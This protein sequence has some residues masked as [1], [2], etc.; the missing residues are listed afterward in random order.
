M[1]RE[2]EGAVAAHYARSDLES[3][4]LEQLAAAGVDLDAL[5]ARDLAPVD[6]FHIGGL[7]ASEALARHL[8][9]GPDCALLDIGCGIGGP[10][11]YFAERLDA[12]VVGIDLTPDFIAVA[13]S[14]TRRVGLAEQVRF[15]Q[16]S[17]L[18]LPFKDA[19]FDC[20]TLLHVGMNIA[21]KKG[22]FAE[23]ARVLR[24]GAVF[25]VYDVMRLAPGDLTFPLPWSSLPET[26][27]VASPEDYRRALAAAG[28]TLAFEQERAAEAKAFFQKQRARIEAGEGGP[29]LAAIM[30]ETFQTK[31]ANMVGLIGT[32]VLAPV[33]VIAVRSSG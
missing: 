20:A 10:A 9:E 27:F 19:Q 24:P 23:A 16:A 7:E 17:A 31:I 33:E 32:G 13:E 30:G 6:E 2:V 25:A 8:P 5:T 1:T 21:D 29:S 26:S 11:R 14:L 3:A 28:F 4:L 22:L 12:V 15:E 18:D